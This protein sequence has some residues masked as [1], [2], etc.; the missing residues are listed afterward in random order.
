VKEIWAKRVYGNPMVCLQMKLKRLKVA[1]R[2]WNKLVFG[3]IDA[4]VKIM[5]IKSKLCFEI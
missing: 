3:N 1:L 5:C 4:N 2:A